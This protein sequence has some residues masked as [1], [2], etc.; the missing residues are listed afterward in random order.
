MLS[1]S[2]NAFILPRSLRTYD[3][4]EEFAKAKNIPTR[5]VVYIVVVVGGFVGW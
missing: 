4:N 5:P 2:K 3:D 1:P